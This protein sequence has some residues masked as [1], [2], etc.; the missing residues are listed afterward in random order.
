MLCAGTG[1]VSNNSF[2]IKEVLE[3]EL[4]KQNLQNEV[5]V[6]MTGCNGFCAVG[7]IMVVRPDGIFYQQLQ[8]DDIPYL[9][10]EHFLKGR[11]VKRLM[12]TPLE[13]KEPIPKMME[14]GFF[15][16]QRLIALRNRGLID[17]E[18]IDEYIARDGYKALAKVLA[19]MTPEEVIEEVKKSGLRGRGGAGFPTGIKWEFCRKAKPKTE[20]QNTKYIICNADEGDPGAFMDRSII[21]SDPHGVLEGMIIGAYAIGANHGYIYIRN[22]Y[23]LAMKRLE[24]AIEQAKEY[25]LLGENIFDTGFS[26]DVKIQRGAGAFV[27]GEETSLMASI[28]GRPAEPRQRPPFPAQ[29][30]VWGLPT[31]INNVETWATVPNVVNRGAEWFASIGTEKSK[32]TKVFSLVGKIN[33]TGLVEVP[34]GITLKEIIYNIGAGIPYG[35][36]FKAVQ[37]GGPSGGCIPKELLNLPI[38]Y[39]RLAEVGSIMGSGGMIVLD[40]DNC[41]VDIAKYFLQFTND[42]SC[43]KCNSCREGS[44]ALLEILNRISNGEGEEGDIVF[45]EELGQAIKDASLCGLGQTL[46]NPVLST[47]RHFRDEYEQHIKYKRCPAAVCKGI[48]SSACQHTCP[49]GQDVPCYIGLIVQGKFEEAIK[50]IRKENPLPSICGRVCHHPC[51]SKCRS[52]EGGGEPIAIRALKRFL[53]DY[54]LEQ[55]IAPEEKP[56]QTRDERVAVI[57]SGPAGLTCAYYLALE[58]Y[59][60]TIFERLPKPGGMLAVGI[61]EYR[62]PKE[63]L[64]FEIDSIGKLGVEIKTNTTVGKD[65]QISELKNEYKA[66]FIGTGAHKGLKLGIPNEETEGVI[67]AVEFLRKVNLGQDIEIGEKVIVVG[68]GNAAVDTARVVKR[69]GRNVQII[70]RRTRTEMPAAKEEVEQVT[71]EEINIQFLTSPVKV[72]SDNGKVTAIE[73]VKMRLGDIDKTGR[74]RPIPIEGSEFRIELD[75]L[76]P[77][78]GQEPDISLLTNGN[79]LKISKWNTI[80]VNPETFYTDEE[81]IFAGG[82]VVTGPQTVTEAM[83]HGKIAARMIGK[84]VRGEEIKREYKITTPAIHV[85]AVELTDEEIEQLKKPQI[86]KLSTKERKENFKEVELGFTEEMAITEAKRC[87]RCDLEEKEE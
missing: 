71:N 46:P 76:I 47:L 86:P 12:Y 45:L 22:E 37:T 78:I 26:F 20:T 31:N 55:G 85:E 35:K 34:M 5:L 62:L 69:L 38:D 19:Q 48:I 3:K 7:P 2:K 64:K 16:R 25:G 65:I 68:G 72:I 30:G 87:L 49:L 74:R 80:D 6:V 53:A 51:E 43:G 56:K 66:I 14:I 67:D 17:P 59:R 54:E 58:G 36:K 50:I 15:A 40:E 28:E 32:G 23:P 4:K 11:P 8:E 42:E 52:G 27:C 77:A 81:G 63:I 1:C 24:I 21:E 39:E 13:E 10:E 75:T 82:D 33:N 9:V 57:G 18:N 79:G 73:C 70:Y 60:V 44:E 84:Y 41:M 83:A 29:S 61:P